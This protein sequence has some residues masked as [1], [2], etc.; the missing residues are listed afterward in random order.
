MNLEELK[1]KIN[2]TQKTNPFLDMKLPTVEYLKSISNKRVWIRVLN[3]DQTFAEEVCTLNK[4]I[5]ETNMVEV[6]TKIGNKNF[7]FDNILGIED[8]SCNYNKSH[9]DFDSLIEKPIR[10]TNYKG[11]SI[12]CIIQY[13]GDETIAFAL[14]IPEYETLSYDLEYPI[15]LIQNIELI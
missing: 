6:N 9:I 2:I 10:M 8:L 5:D 3:D 13:V 7:K 12:E 11:D 14:R 1:D 15:N 4:Y